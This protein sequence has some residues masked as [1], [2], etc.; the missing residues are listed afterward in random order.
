MIQDILSDEGWKYIAQYI[1]IDG[2]FNINSTSVNAWYALLQG[3]QNRKLVGRDGDSL[4]IVERDKKQEEVLFSRFGTSTTTKSLEN[5]GSYDPLKGADFRGKGAYITAWGEVRK[6]SPEQLRKLA[7]QI[8]VQVKKRGPFLNM[9]DFVNRRLDAKDT[10]SSLAGTLQAAIDAT[11]INSMFNRATVP[12]TKGDLYK[13][14]EAENGSVHTAAPGYLVQS[15]ILSSIGNVLTVRDDTFTI[16]AYGCVKDKS[17]KRILSQAWCE[18]TVQ[19]CIEYVDSANNVEELPYK[20]D[21]T[22]TENMTDVN[23]AFGRKFR[24]V[25]FRWLDAAEV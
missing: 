14:P 17:G 22:R 6:L 16:R 5:F 24:I 15:D 4:A 12:S 2:G 25:A 21:G 11:E 3:L 10:A 1:L 20:D 23:I 13:F 7:E 18:A 19:R 8:V 9:A